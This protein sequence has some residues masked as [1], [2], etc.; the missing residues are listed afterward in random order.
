MSGRACGVLCCRGQE[1]GVEGL[2]G[3]QGKSFAVG[4]GEKRLLGLV[5]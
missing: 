1:F 2:L 5:P 4:I 3:S